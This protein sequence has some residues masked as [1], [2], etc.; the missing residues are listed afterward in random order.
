MEINRLG[1]KV[2]FTNTSKKYKSQ[3]KWSHITAYPLSRICS[4]CSLAFEKKEEMKKYYITGII[5][6]IIAL[7]FGL[8]NQVRVAIP[9]ANGNLTYGWAANITNAGASL[10]FAVAGGLC[11]LAA[12]LSEKDNKKFERAVSADG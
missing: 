10:G 3:N 9:L 6:L 8:F 2:P 1:M 7:V 11:M 5:C 4:T 12:A